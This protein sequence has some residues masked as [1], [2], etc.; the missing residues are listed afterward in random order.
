MSIVKAHR[1]LEYNLK[2]LA[3]FQFF[4]GFVIMMPVIVVFYQSVGLSMRD[5]MI[6]QAVFSATT[7]LFEIPSGYFSDVLGR[8]R[9]LILGTICSTLGFALYTV[10]NG[11]AMILLSELVLGVGVSFISGTDSAM[12]FDTLSELGAAERSVQTEGRQLSYSNFAESVA[13]VLAG[14]LTAVSLRTPLYAQVLATAVMIPLAWSLVEPSRQRFRPTQGSFRAILEISHSALIRNKRLR[15]LL[16]FSGVIGS[17]T[18]TMVWFVQPYFQR[19]S[20]DVRYFGVAW[21][22]FNLSVGLFS[23]N[24]HRI[25]RSLPERVV[26]GLMMALLVFGFLGSAGWASLWSLPILLCFYAVRGINNPIFNT[27]I[28]RLVPSDRRATVLS[29]RQLVTRAVFCVTGPL[30]GWIA[31]SYSQATALAGCAILYSAAG[32]ALFLWHHEESGTENVTEERA[33][34]ESAEG[35]VGLA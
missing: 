35:S 32:L 18:L 3:V 25:E 29:I 23:M 9:T 12:L 2:A 13:G 1:S 31:D 21:T 11:F 7:V 34:N 4:K 26:I 10:S 15:W 30:S 19:A 24:A 14:F 8:R 27:Y 5:I 17:G 33:D 16:V 22:L 28:N 20:L 6:T